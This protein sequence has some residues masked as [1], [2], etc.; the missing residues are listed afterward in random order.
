[1]SC[2]KTEFGDLVHAAAILLQMREQQTLQV[3]VR[4][5][6][7]HVLHW[8]VFAFAVVVEDSTLALEV[9]LE[10]DRTI[11]KVRMVDDEDGLH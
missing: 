3:E 9:E 7:R 5:T 2:R 11:V 6:I 10:A 1:M 8:G 4:P